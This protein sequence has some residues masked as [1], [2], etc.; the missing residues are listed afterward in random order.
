MSHLEASNRRRLKMPSEWEVLAKRLAFAL[1]LVK[2]AE[3]QLDKL[4]QRK[5][6][7]LSPYEEYDVLQVFVE[8]QPTRCVVVTAV[9]WRQRD[10]YCLRVRELTIHGRLTGRQKYSH[11]LY[12]QARKGFHVEKQDQQL[13][14][15][16]R[17]QLETREYV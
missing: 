5:A 13:D 8:G 7:E 3:A 1:E 15:D 17:H 4:R 12:P 16:V 9:E 14:A 2:L 6:A 10:G 11:L